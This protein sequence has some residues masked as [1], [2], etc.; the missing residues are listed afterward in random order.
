M[1][2]Y[3]I[4]QLNKAK[5]CL[6]FGIPIFMTPAAAQSA[7][8]PLKAKVMILGVYH[9]DNPNQD[10]V[11][12]NV[13]DHLSEQRQKQIAEV[14]ELLAK[15]KPTKIALEA[16]EG[17]TAVHRHYA[18][19]LKGEYTLSVDERDQLGLRLAKE[20]DHPK[21]YAIDHKLD[22]DFASVVAAAQQSGDLKFLT[23]FQTVMTEIQDFQKRQ[24]T[25]TVREILIFMNEANQIAKGHNVYLQISRVRHGEQFVGADVLAGW[26][27]RNFRIFSNLARVAA[28]PEDRILVIF[29]SGHAPILRELVQASPDLQLAEPNDYLNKP[30]T[31]GGNEHEK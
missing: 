18:A 6:V 19:Y 22:M 17:V 12:T 26:Y 20:L 13:D 27:Q 14:S 28:S 3:F 11:K 15:F 29:G 2:N 25:M 16:V 7:K 23:T 31:S 5:F 1:K 30:G 21:V 4:S 10:Y 8:E 24:A 9:M